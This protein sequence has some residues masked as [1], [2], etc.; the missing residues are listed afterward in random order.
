MWF[1]LARSRLTP[2]RGI[3]VCVS[4]ALGAVAWWWFAGA[5]DS[6]G[7]G[8]KRMA[9]RLDRIAENVRMRPGAFD[10]LRR[11][12]EIRALLD[13]SVD[14]DA[15]TGLR[16]GLGGEL[17]QAGRTDD[18]I[19]ELLEVRTRVASGKADPDLSKTVGQLLAISFLRMG[20]QQNCIA[21]HGVDSCL[22]PIR[23]AGL[24]RIE[25]GSR[26]AI[27]EYQALLENAPDDLI[28]RWLLNLAHMTVGGYPDDVPEPW[29]IPPETFASEDPMPR[30]YDIA[31]LREIDVIGLAGGSIVEDFDRDGFLDVM[32][33]SCGLRDPLR[34]F[35]NDGN[36]AFSDRTRAAGLNGLVGGLNL[37][38][39][40]YD[41]DGFPDVLV[42]RGA[43]MR[44]FG[45]H[46]NSLLHNGRDGTFDDV[47]DEAGVLSFHPTQT[48]AWADYDNDGWLD[49]FIGN[50]STPGDIHPCEFYRNNG[51]GT[52]TSCAADI[53][54]GGIVGVIKGAVWGD[55]DND[56]FPDLY[57]SRYAQP[58][59]LFRNVGIDST[60]RARGIAARGGRGFVNV[61]ESMNVGEP[62]LSFTSWF[63]DY[64]NDGWEDLLVFGYHYGGEV[65]ASV[66]ADYLGLPHDGAKPRL[67]R[68]EQ[69]TGFTDV[70]AQV[71]LD[72][73]ILAMGANFG[74]L[75]NDGFLDFYAGTG[76]P[77][78]RCLVPNRMFRNAAGREFREV[79]TAG[80]FGHLQKGHGVAF[81][82]L[83][84]DGD[85][86]LY[87]VMGGFYSGDF[88]QN[89][90]FENPGNDAS[91]ITL[92]LEGLK[93]NR[94]ALGAR[95][96]V[97]LETPEGTRE[98]HRTVTTG[99]SFGSSSLQ[100]EIGLGDATAIRFVEI[101]WPG[102]GQTQRFENLRPKH[103]YR[104]IEG[105]ATAEIV[106][107]TAIAMS[108]TR[109]KAR[110]PAAGK[111][112]DHGVE[113]AKV[114]LK[115]P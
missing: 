46:P 53:G 71:G 47:T 82:D 29:R 75:D 5:S 56:G 28:S 2:A 43:W 115:L 106:P 107:S 6:R 54:L 108:P 38:H 91:W 114:D 66:V 96:R 100:Q 8:T 69:G 101:H 10:N 18:A 42:L 32:A 3:L 81:G 78:L 95:I 51:N 111:S 7:P 65:V 13:R 112:H 86:D 98:I 61:T 79:T 105:V 62:V 103:V 31:P 25:N 40:D 39:A 63:W 22:F 50:E 21:D 97:S 74:D 58:N 99:G 48:A 20:E 76:T 57:L 34:F 77:D 11:A 17:L 23:D 110:P 33:S 109:G 49:L 12:K 83:D 14:P 41:N 37:C 36:G 102:S 72:R 55:I 52:F 70:T 89:L 93:T 92:R 19:R 88:Y 85:E 30:F 113:N 60:G 59:L 90:L 9:G 1:S 27:D 104:M 44:E 24:H 16:I 80:G 94:S 4:V 64:D 45:H 67:Y 84:N 87:V 15:E 73:V 35:R 68:N 26:K